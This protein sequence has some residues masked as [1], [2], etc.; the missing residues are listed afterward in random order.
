MVA[1]YA[2]LWV[3]NLGPVLGQEAGA[4]C[5]VCKEFLNR[6]YNSLIA[7]GVN[8]SL[9]TIEKELVSFCLDVKGKE[10][11]LCYYLGATKD[12]AT[13]ILSEVARPM[14]VHMPATKICEKLKKMDSQICELKYGIMESN[15]FFHYVQSIANSLHRGPCF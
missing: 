14:S 8:F 15:V 6:F 4:D 10:N 7:R 13:K 5:E 9:D 3:S 1:F 2:G 11:R 12:A